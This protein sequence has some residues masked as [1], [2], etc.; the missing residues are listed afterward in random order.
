MTNP[1]KELDG[2]AVFWFTPPRPEK[3]YG[4]VHY[5]DENRDGTISALAIC[6]Y[7]G[8]DAAYV[9]A[10]NAHWQVIGDLLY[11]SVEEAKKDAERYYNDGRSINW[12]NLPDSDVKEFGQK[13][14]Q[15]KK[16]VRASDFA[17]DQT[18]SR[19]V[20]EGKLVDAIARLRKLNDLSLLEAKILVERLKDEL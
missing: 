20:R 18:I 14:G 10:C 12:V 17:S 8:S 6:Q 7:S 3:N 4:F 5:V 16:L 11:Y 9:F 2:A 1:P 13:K 15:E 19:L